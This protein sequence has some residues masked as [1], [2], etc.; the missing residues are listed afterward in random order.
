MAIE[1][2]LFPDAFRQEIKMNVQQN[3]KKILFFS[4]KL[5]HKYLK[6][7]DQCSKTNDW[8]QSISNKLTL[9][10]LTSKV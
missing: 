1:I 5:Q 4:I 7:F 2:N 10:H 6:K 3:Y 8:L 9:K